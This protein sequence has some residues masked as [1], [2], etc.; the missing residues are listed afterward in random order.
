MIKS[1]SAADAALMMQLGC[2]GG[3]FTFPRHKEKQSC[4]LKTPVCLLL[5]FRRLRNFPSPSLF[6]VCVVLLFTELII[7]ND[8]SVR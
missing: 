6:V 5:S 1:S 7:M 2:D 3:S 8:R 4:V